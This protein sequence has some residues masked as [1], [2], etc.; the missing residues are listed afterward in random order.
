M[1]LIK[2]K[3]GSKKAFLKY[4]YYKVQSLVG[5]F[6][7]YDVQKFGKPTRLVF[8][9]AGNICR[10][11][12]AEAAALNMGAIAISFGFDTRGEDSADAR[13]IAYGHQR[14]LDLLSHRT[15]KIQDYKPLVG[16]LI[17]VME[18]KHL[19]LYAKLHIDYPITLLGLYGENP[20]PYIH[21]PYSSNE[22]YFNTCEELILNRTAELIGY[23]KR[24]G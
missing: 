4:Y 19:G 15:K 22:K 17:V 14:G 21:D 1:K 23:I 13:A 24:C 16:D 10:S 5:F 3:F 18:P 6:K 9:C 12:L 20:V 2:D 7:T 11:P 8:V